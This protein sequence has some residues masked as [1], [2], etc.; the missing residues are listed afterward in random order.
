M[1][2]KSRSHL[3]TS[4][5]HRAF[6]AL[7]AAEVR[8][9]TSTLSLRDLLRDS[10]ALVDGLSSRFDAMSLTLGIHIER[11]EILEMEPIDPQ[12]LRD[13]SARI[14]EAIR[15]EAEGAWLEAL[16]RLREKKDASNAR[17][18]SASLLA[19]LAAVE[20][21]R[22]VAASESEAKVEG[23]LAGEAGALRVLAARREREEAELSI[24]L[25]RSRRTAEAERDAALV[26]AAVDEQK[27]QPVRDLELAKLVAERTTAAMGSW[28]IRDAR[29][30]SLGE[31]SPVTSIASLI[32]GVRE[33]VRPAK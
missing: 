19:R 30:V 14:E 16:D 8:A 5:Q 6:Q 13:V 15:E 27:S 33:L 3:L 20:G 17:E 12:I 26:R 7:L 10:R 18:A 31:T 28:Q 25:D 11:T 2:Q 23:Q 21:D 1:G 4:A 24:T 22:R 32:G 29:W 9:H